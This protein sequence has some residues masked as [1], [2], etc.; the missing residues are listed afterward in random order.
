MKENFFIV[1]FHNAGTTILTKLLNMHPD[2]YLL[3]SKG[4]ANL[5]EVVL[6]GVALSLGIDFDFSPTE[7]VLS[8]GLNSALITVNDGVA[9]EFR[10]RFNKIL[11]KDRRFLKNP[12]LFYYKDLL[13]KAFPASKRILILRN[14]YSY[15]IS[16]NYWKKGSDAG[17]EKLQKRARYWSVAMEYCFDVWNRDTNTLILRYRDL[18]SSTKDVINKICDF[19]DLDYGKVINELPNTLTN[20]DYKWGLFRDDLKPMVQNEVDTVM[21]KYFE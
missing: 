21:G 19:V 15:T 11:G 6:R 14:G 17:I 10:D 20:M 4:Y 5:E 18:C 2:V 12:R 9:Q 1:G 3:T 7:R 13:D 8:T 16:K